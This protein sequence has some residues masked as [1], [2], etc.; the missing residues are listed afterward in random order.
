MANVF[1][2]QFPTYLPA[3]RIITNITQDI[4]AVITTSFDNSYISG[5]IVRISVPFFKGYYPWG[6]QQILDQQGEIEVLNSTQFKI[7]IDTRY[8]DPFITP[9]GYPRQR[10]FVVPIGENNAILAAATTN[11]LLPSLGI[12]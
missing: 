11:V 8:Y 3:M 4:E 9:P 6:M 5:E 12:V 1:A 10:P 7:S 2:I